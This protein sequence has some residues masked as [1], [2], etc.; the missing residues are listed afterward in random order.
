MLLSTLVLCSRLRLYYAPIGVRLNFPTTWG[1]PHYLG[2]TGLQLLGSQGDVI[3][4]DIN[5]LDA[6]PRDLQIMPGYERD[7]RT[8]DK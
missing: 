5:M 1:D 3:P 4:L 7:D 8:L 2:L 6:D